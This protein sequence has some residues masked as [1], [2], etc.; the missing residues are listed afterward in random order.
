MMP[1]VYISQSIAG[2]MRLSA[3]GTAA[4]PA[5]AAATLALAAKAMFVVGAMVIRTAASAGSRWPPSAVELNANSDPS[6]LMKVLRNADEVF[7]LRR[8]PHSF[9]T[10][11]RR[12][13]D[14][15]TVPLDLK[16]MVF[17]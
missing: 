10:F 13:L 6:L 9:R 3:A 8:C 12:L 4:D 7:P 11:G 2:A 15:W 14:C 16:R 17:R 1:G 5:L